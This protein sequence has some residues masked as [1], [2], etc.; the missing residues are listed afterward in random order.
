MHGGGTETLVAPRVGRSD[1]PCPRAGRTTRRRTA[2][3]REAQVRSQVVVGF[4][5]VLGDTWG[6]QQIRGRP[7]ATP[8]S[9][10][11]LALGL[12]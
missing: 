4:V 3:G 5:L 11:C 10:E 7:I 6:A 8:H 1:A 9:G 12:V 2:G